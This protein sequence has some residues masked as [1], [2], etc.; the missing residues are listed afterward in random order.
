MFNN[1]DDLCLQYDMYDLCL[2]Y[3]MCLFFIVFERTTPKARWIERNI[4][5]LAG[6]ALYLPCNHTY[7]NPPAKYKWTTVICK[8]GA[9][10]GCRGERPPYLHGQKDGRITMDKNGQLLFSL[11]L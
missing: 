3:D 11:L 7:S 9:A 8:T 4:T 2:Q 1:S 5:Q 10:R 6:S